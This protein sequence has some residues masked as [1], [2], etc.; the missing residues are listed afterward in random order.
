MLDFFERAKGKS[1]MRRV[2]LVT[3][4]VLISLLSISSTSSDEMIGLARVNT[5]CNTPV[6]VISMR[7]VE[8]VEVTITNSDGTSQSN[9]INQNVSTKS[10]A[11][12]VVRNPC[13][14][15]T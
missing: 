5:Q 1:I 11:P 6:A 15:I 14:N 10:N 4:L 8:K 3:S 7:I 9:I 13:K 12:G 2:G